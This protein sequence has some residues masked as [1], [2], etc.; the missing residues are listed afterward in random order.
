MGFPKGASDMKIVNGRGDSRIEQHCQWWRTAY[1]LTTKK[2]NYS[3]QKQT[4]IFLILFLYFF[5]YFSSV[6]F[7]H[8]NNSIFASTKKPERKEEAARPF[9]RKQN[10]FEERHNKSD[11]KRGPFTD[12]IR[13]REELKAKGVIIRFHRWPKSKQR[14]EIINRLKAVGLKKTKSIKSFKA[15]V[16]DWSPIVKGGRLM[17]SLEAERACQKLKDLSS[18]K[19]CSPNH[20]LPL[21]DQSHQDEDGKTEASAEKGSCISCRHR[22]DNIST[23]LSSLPPPEKNIKTCN[24]VSYKHNLM[25]G[26]LSDY[27]AQEL[28]GADLLKDL[29]KKEGGTLP[30][31]LRV[32]VF[33]SHHGHHMDHVAHLI[34]DEGPH[35]V[36]P[37]L[38]DEQLDHFTTNY[39]GDWLE[40]A[41]QIKR[42][43]QHLHFINNSMGWVGS[44]DI[45]DAVDYLSPPAIVVTGSG[46]ESEPLSSVKVDASTGLGVIAVGSFSP[47]GF[48]SN[49]SNYGEEVHILAPSD[50]WITSTGKEGEYERFSGTSGATPLVTGSLAGFEWLSGYHPTPQEAKIL[51]ERTAFPTLH[52]H[53]R[54][55]VNGVGLVNAY[56]LGKVGQKLKEKCKNDVSCFKKEISKDENYHFNLNTEKL[57][58][59]LNRT[60]P[61]CAGNNE[62]SIRASQNATSS[63]EK[64]GEVF[65]ELRKTVLLHPTC[66]KHSG[67]TH[68]SRNSESECNNKDIKE[69]LGILS[70]IYRKGGFSKNAE[71][72]DNLALAFNSTDQIRLFVKEKIDTEESLPVAI[73]RFALTMEGFQDQQEKLLGRAIVAGLSVGLPILHRAFNTGDK[74]RKLQVLRVIRDISTKVFNI[75]KTLSPYALSIMQQALES[76][77]QDLQIEAVRAA[78]FIGPQASHIVEEAFK[79][80]NQDLQIEA[81]RT[82]GFIG[83]QASHIVEE[84]FKSTNQDL[85]IE[86]VYAAKYI[87]P[88]ASHIVEEAFKSGNQDVQIAAVHAAYWVGRGSILSRALRS[89]NQNLQVAAARAAQSLGRR[90]LFILEE[91]FESDNRAVQIGI[92]YAAARMGPP[93]LSVVRQ[94]FKSREQDMQIAAVYAAGGIGPEA[95]DIVES[96]LQSNDQV[97][98]IEAVRAA[99]RVGPEVLPSLQQT[100]DL[101]N[102]HVREKVILSMVEPWALPF[103]METL[104]RT[105]LDSE[106]REIIN[107]RI[108]QI[109]SKT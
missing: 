44:R 94:A 106:M 48:V 73:I 16:F 32:A 50:H 8:T 29:I 81:V 30:P 2:K 53:E 66:T 90:A 86:A 109:L 26:D 5:L 108:Q 18:I 59:N 85:Q 97:V 93:A 13:K 14:K 54:P 103:L 82:A 7:I 40:A 22:Q 87:G 52:I 105:D 9:Q 99:G 92:L 84:A 55:K 23:I 58:E 100:F 35:A 107:K 101:G 72:L 56:K 46:N 49:F 57:K 67:S 4:S 74:E 3:F 79:S 63:C 20:L 88:Q 17:P 10:R 75:E 78:G 60:F 64:K 65:A 80:T 21:D 28:I 12:R 71:G 77:D 102:Q 37:K 62:D 76:G 27:W 34:S 104:K 43:N 19:R 69:F 51:L 68:T 91:A 96:A 1:R 98:Q 39:P 47:H 24:L 15:W 70:C 31:K 41:E 36:L 38:D 6:T 45:Y 25:D 61:S 42:Q 89:K 11:I 83:P 95:L 33:D